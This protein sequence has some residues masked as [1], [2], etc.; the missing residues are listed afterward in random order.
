MK[1]GMEMFKSFNIKQTIAFG[2]LCLIVVGC[3]SY[4]PY[5]YSFSLIEPQNEAM[6][7]EDEDVQF[8]FVPHAENIRITIKNK[9]GHTISI[10]RDNAKYIDIAGESL[11]IHYGYDYVQEVV[12]FSNGMHVSEMNIASNSEITGYAW[13]NNWPDFHIGQ[14][15]GNIPISTYNIDNRKEP[16]FPRYSFEGKGEDL[17]NSTFNLILPIDFCE[18][19]RDYTFTF[20]IDDVT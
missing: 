14:G 13:I 16:F 3:S 6:S 2:F 9:T 15:P 17:K 18:Y 20:K 8:K 11:G 1:E 7:F 10:V 19:V 5:R 4:T 12:N